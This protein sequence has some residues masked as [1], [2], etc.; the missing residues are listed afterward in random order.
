MEAT[1]ETNR[2]AMSPSAVVS[3]LTFSCYAFN[4]R[5]TPSI[6]PEGWER[7]F[8]ANTAAMEERFQQELRA[9]R[10]AGER[11]TPSLNSTCQPKG[12]VITKDDLQR[13]AARVADLDRASGCNDW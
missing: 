8:G 11:S 7:V 4:R 13:D 5:N 6:P 1:L 9:E 10:Q 12:S 2:G 3:E